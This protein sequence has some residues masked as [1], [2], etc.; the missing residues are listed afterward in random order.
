MAD[1][2]VSFHYQ[3]RISDCKVCEYMRGSFGT[4][5]C[6]VHNAFCSSTCI[7]LGSNQCQNFKR[8]VEWEED[9]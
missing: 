6:G 8:A 2:T 1:N 4:R 5:V 7:K 3:K 9:A